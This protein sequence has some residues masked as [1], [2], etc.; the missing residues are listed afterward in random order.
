VDRP[1]DPFDVKS[2]NLMDAFTP[3]VWFEAGTAKH[4]LGTDNQGRD[5]LSASSTAAASRS[6]IGAGWRSCSR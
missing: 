6:L 2:L 1:F 4:L 3:P 5:M